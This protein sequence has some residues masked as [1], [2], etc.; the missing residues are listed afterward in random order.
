LLDISLTMLLEHLWRCNMALAYPIDKGY[1]STIPTT[2]IHEVMVFDGVAHKIRRVTVHTF[3]VGDAE[4]PD[5]YAA[6]PL[7]DWEHSEMG[8]W[9][10]ERAIEE[11]EWH[12]EIDNI[13][14]G[15]R[16]AVT[17]KLKEQDYLLWILKWK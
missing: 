7:Y 6:Q 10:R 13:S 1:L 12:R 17:A 2:P 15:Y 5:L 11:C 16:Y 14:W 4:D 3:T 9:V 8:Q